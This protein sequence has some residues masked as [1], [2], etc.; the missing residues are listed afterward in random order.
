MNG[1]KPKTIIKMKD[2][3]KYRAIYCMNC[4]IGYGNSERIWSMN[5]VSR[6]YHFF[7]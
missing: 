4:M 3:K 1:E 2:T 5:V 7:S 6:H